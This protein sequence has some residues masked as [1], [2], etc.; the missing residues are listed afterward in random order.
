[1][2]SVNIVN[3]EL[4]KDIKEMNQEIDSLYIVKNKIK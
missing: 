3:T 1:M 2:D 4:F